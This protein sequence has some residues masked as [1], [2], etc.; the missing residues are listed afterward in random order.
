MRARSTAIA[1]DPVAEQAAQDFL[2]GG[3]S[4]IGAV[5]CGYFAAAGAH[6]GVLFSPLTI[7]VG[8][9]GAGARAFDGRLRQPGL[10]TKRP[11]GFK[12]GESIP[13]AARVGVPSS[14]SAALVAHA[15]DSEQRLR[16][17]MK[18]AVSRAERSGAEARAELLRRI[19]AVGAAALT[20]PSFVRPLLRAAGPSEGGLLTPADF[21]QIPD[22]DRDATELKLKE[23]VLYEAPWASEL[24]EE[25]DVER[26]GIGCAVLAADV[27]GVFAALCYRRITNG[28]LVDDLD[29]ELPLI[30]VPVQRGV[31]RLSPGA[32]LS[33]PAP[34][35]IVRDA[36]GT[37]IEAVAAPAAARLDAQALDKVPLRIRRDPAALEVVAHRS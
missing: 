5:L 19:R 2:I 4:A 35:G 9:I 16:T 25:P 6:A 10:G 26:D 28:I 29:V 18:E 15:Y 30:A 34:I 32:R 3:G 21:G 17:I 1:N 36:R 33:A 37:V 8:G 7:L 24:S 14:V 27:R 23:R 11:R 12:P 13:D 31:A 22:I 20:E